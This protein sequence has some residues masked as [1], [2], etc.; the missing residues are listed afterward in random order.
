ME[1]KFL[2]HKIKNLINKYCYSDLLLIIF[3]NVRLTL[4][5]Y[6]YIQFPINQLII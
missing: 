1:F 4:K 3:G 6:K 5:I 2:T